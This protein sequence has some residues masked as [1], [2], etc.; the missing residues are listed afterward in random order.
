MIDDC[1]IDCDCA[2]SECMVGSAFALGLTAGMMMTDA[3]CE[4]DD[5]PRSE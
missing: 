2:D 4:R 3:E 5:C 1:P